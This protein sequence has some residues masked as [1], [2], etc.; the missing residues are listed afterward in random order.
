[1]LASPLTFPPAASPARIAPTVPS[2]GPLRATP[3]RSPSKPITLVSAVTPVCPPSATPSRAVKTAST[4]STTTAQRQPVLAAPTARRQLT[5]LTSKPSGRPTALAADPG[6]VLSGSSS[7][8]P[9]QRRLGLNKT[10]LPARSSPPSSSTLS[11]TTS[12]PKSTAPL[13]AAA[14][15]PSVSA[16]PTPSI[17]R[18]KLAGPLKVAPSKMIPPSSTASRTLAPSRMMAPSARRTTAMTDGRPGSAASNSSGVSAPTS[19]LPRPRPTIAKSMKQASAPSTASSLAK[20]TAAAS[21]ARRGLT[22]STVSSSARTG[23]TP[24][25]RPPSLTAALAAR[26]PL[27]SSSTVQA[28]ATATGLLPR[29]HS[30]ASSGLPSSRLLPALAPA[31]SAPSVLSSEVRP[32]PSPA[33]SPLPVQPTLPLLPRP[34]P[35]NPTPRSPEKRSAQRVVRELPADR[36]TK[37]NLASRRSARDFSDRLF[38]YSR[39]RRTSHLASL[40]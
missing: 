16:L 14:S 37:V 23:I 18:S 30:A 13:P 6:K 31:N 1:M 7:V 15:L 28:V 34:V 26:A 9:S 20:P 40:P 29:P 32:M 4:P 36:L 17:A 22:T 8:A 33:P 19:T 12:I 5:K 11:R 39:T 27:P 10:T 25:P 2:N 3:R 24:S 38:F 21:V 35:L